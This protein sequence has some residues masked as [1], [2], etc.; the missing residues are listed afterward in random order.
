VFNGQ[1]GFFLFNDLGRVWVSGEDSGKWHDGFG[2]GAWLTPFDFTA[3]T[4]TYS[5][6]KEDR[7]LTF[8]FSFLF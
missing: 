6:S 7:L 3:L 5:R 2:V 1:T 4:L 8:A